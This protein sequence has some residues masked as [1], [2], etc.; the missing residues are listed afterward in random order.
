MLKKLL[1]RR[2]LQPANGSYKNG[3]TYLIE[4]RDVVKQYAARPFTALKNIN[5]QVDRVCG[6]NP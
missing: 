2:E 6:G 3:N 1:I 5:L 4:L